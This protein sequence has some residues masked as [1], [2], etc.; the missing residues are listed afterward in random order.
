MRN[1]KCYNSIVVKGEAIEIP[2]SLRRDVKHRLHSAHLGYDSMI[3][4]ARGTIFW[5]KH[6]ETRQLACVVLDKSMLRS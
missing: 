3:R 4:R 1:S 6:A 5:P 2:K